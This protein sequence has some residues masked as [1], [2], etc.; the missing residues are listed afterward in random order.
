MSAD[1]VFCSLLWVTSSEEGSKSWNID[2]K[3]V[4]GKGNVSESEV[5]AST[6]IYT[7]IHN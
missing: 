6:E 7:H 5:A 3:W 4:G 2:L 1:G